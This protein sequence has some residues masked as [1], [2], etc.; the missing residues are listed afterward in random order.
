MGLLISSSQL[1][2]HSL[3][4]LEARL[5]AWLTL[6]KDLT[7]GIEPDKLPAS[8]QEGV[9]V[10]TPELTMVLC[11]KNNPSIPQDLI[12]CTYFT[13]V[14]YATEFRIDQPR[15]TNLTFLCILYYGRDSIIAGR[16]TPLIS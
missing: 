16:S 6:R 12:S 5:I 4:L 14:P 10:L 11:F 9:T 15:P 13:L 8:S 7:S 3:S 1:R 2:S